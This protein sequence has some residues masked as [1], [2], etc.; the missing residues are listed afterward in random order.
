V[1]DVELSVIGDTRGEPSGY[2]SAIA[3]VPDG[4]YLMIDGQRALKVN[5]LG[6]ALRELSD[7]SA[8]NVGERLHHANWTLTTDPE[9]VRR[10][11]LMHD[12]AACRAG[13][14]QALARLREVP[15]GEIAVGQ[16]WWAP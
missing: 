6:R 8:A 13:V 7:A 15:D 9:T 1:T 12:C 3:A 5:V 14:D 2:D 11:G 16:L 4:C 10:L